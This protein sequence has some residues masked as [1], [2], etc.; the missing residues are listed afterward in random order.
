M[1]LSKTCWQDAGINLGFTA[2]LAVA[3]VPEPSYTLLALAARQAT[4]AASSENA[5]RAACPRS[6]HLRL[7]ELHPGPD[8]ARTHTTLCRPR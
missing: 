2:Q 4:F 8:Y 3:A 6:L 7:R 1:S 5:G